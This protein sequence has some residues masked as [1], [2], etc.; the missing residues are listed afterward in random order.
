MSEANDHVSEEVDLQ[1]SVQELARRVY[2]PLLRELEAVYDDEFTPAAHSAYLFNRYNLFSHGG[3]P[4]L[5]K[6]RNR[7]VHGSGLLSDQFALFGDE[8]ELQADLQVAVLKLL[9]DERPDI[10]LVVVGREIVDRNRK[11]TLSQRALV[12]VFDTWADLVQRVARG[13]AILPRR[14]PD[15]RDRGLEA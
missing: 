6:L 5:R 10:F 7:I 3:R 15:D 8:R 1:M 11:P 14:H 2:K 4:D 12:Q 9:A 13:E